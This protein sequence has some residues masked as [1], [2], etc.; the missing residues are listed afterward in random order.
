VEFD[1]STVFR[2]S[3]LAD[4]RDA[5]VDDDDQ[6]ITVQSQRMPNTR[7][8]E[9]KKER[10][11]YTFQRAQVQRVT[12]SWSSIYTYPHEHFHATEVSFLQSHHPSR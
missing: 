1:H 4:A 6:A 10:N 9:K 3:Q 12:M 11:R 8:T 2:G 7:Q 5:V